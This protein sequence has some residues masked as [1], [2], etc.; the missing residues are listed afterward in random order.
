MIKINS[1]YFIPIKILNINSIR[2]L[3]T[4]LGFLSQQIQRIQK[5]KKTRKFLLNL[6]NA[7]DFLGEEFPTSGAFSMLSSRA[8]NSLC[9]L[10]FYL[11][12]G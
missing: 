8:Y 1:N 12:P 11:G 4:G 9:M 3:N 6:D 7:R 10:F 2:I 5:K